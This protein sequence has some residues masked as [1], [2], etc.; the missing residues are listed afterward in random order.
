MQEDKFEF[1]LTQD[2]GIPEDG[3]TKGADT[4]G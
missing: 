1:C 3:H 2:K 4:M